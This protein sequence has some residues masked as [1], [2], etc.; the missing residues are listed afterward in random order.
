MDTLRF[1]D[2]ATAAAYPL[3][4]TG[5]LQ[6]ETPGRAGEVQWRCPLPALDAGTILVPGLS[7]LPLGDGDHVWRL[8]AGARCWSL[9]PV[10]GRPVTEQAPGP[11]TPA[12]A[13]PAV[14]CHIDCFHVHEPLAAA[15][16]ELE[17]QGPPPARYLVTVSARP[18]DL[19]QTAPPDREA[20]LALA[21]PAVSQMTADSTLARRI[22]SPTCVAMVM[23]H[24]NRH[25]GPTGGGLASSDGGS[26]PVAQ[27]AT[28]EA[29]RD[30]MVAACRDP[31]TG[32]FGVWPL[33]LRAAAGLG[34]LG[35]VELFAG[36]DAPL[37]VLDAGIPLVA[38]IRFGTGQLARAPLEQTGG[39]LVLLHRAGPQRVLVNDP[40]AATEAE[41]RREYDSAEFS[42]AWLSHRGAAYIL[43]P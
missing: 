34:R 42:R 30:A 14:T 26:R 20:G 17:L 21:P 15:Q 39:H 22:C 38:S 18:I 40:A 33:A 37:A 7:F 41:V 2:T 29:V 3:A 35:A 16:L 24:W 27:H 11:T 9:N 12:Q 43:L 5:P 28:P 8:R 32:M 6:W 36:W 10:P 31:A 25:P 19:A 23:L 13:A 4:I 1:A